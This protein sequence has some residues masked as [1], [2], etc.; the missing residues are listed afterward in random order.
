[1]TALVIGADRQCYCCTTPLLLPHYNKTPGDAK[2]LALIVH[3]IAILDDSPSPN[4]GLEFMP[5]VAS[6]GINIL[7][8]LLVGEPP[9]TNVEMFCA[10]L[11]SDVAILGDERTPIALPLPLPRFVCTFL[12]P[13][14]LHDCSMSSSCLACECFLP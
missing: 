1:V 10:I 12:C 4:V 11:S 6:V 8:S 2:L 5:I 13:I 14:V 9:Y 3:S 7:L